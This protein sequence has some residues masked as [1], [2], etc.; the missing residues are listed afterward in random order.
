MRAERAERLRG[1]LRAHGVPALLITGAENVRYAVGFW[2][3]EFQLQAA[4]A[5]FFA[6]HEPVVFAPAGSYHQMP[7]QAPWIPHWRIAR[8]WMGGTVSEGAAAEEAKLFADGIAAELSERGLVG[9]P[10]AVSEFDNRAIEALTAQDI[11]VRAGLPLLMESSRIKT[12]DEIS[13]L[14]MVAS[15]STN[16][17]MQA[18]ESLRPGVLQSKVAREVKRASEE[19][20]A[21]FGA[22]KVMAGPLAF[23]RGISGSDRRLEYGDLAYVLTCG[24][25]FLGYTACLYRQYVVGRSATAQEQGLYSELH[26]RMDTVIGELRPGSSTADVAA[27]FAPASKFG[28]A[29]EAELLTI[30]YAHGIGLV[31]VG[32][33]FVHYNYPII[34]RQWSLRYPEEIEEGMVIAVEG[35]E[36]QHRGGGVRTESMVVVTA[37]GPELIDHFPRDEI[38]V[39]GAI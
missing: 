35:I 13:C 38:L 26:D 25:S 20:G 10:L 28:F 31:N 34:N 6:E 16:A 17:F 39:A 24:T 5:L 18:L 9:E 15:I 8:S 21:E 12:Q 11:E 32:S 36:G 33:R 30:E 14:K 4:Y 37:D 19:A 27:H 3:S 2:W 1:V 22:S 7:D 29:D 23:E